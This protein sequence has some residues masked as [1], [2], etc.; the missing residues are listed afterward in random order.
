MTHTEPIDDDE[1]NLWLVAEFLMSHAK[2]LLLGGITGAIIGFGGW[3][4]FAP[5]KGELVVNVERL[6]NASP[7]IDYMTWRNHQQSLP[8][9][10][11]QM[12][13]SGKIKDET[14]LGDYK[15]FSNQQWWRKNVVPT[16]ALTKADTKSLF[17]ISKELQDTEANTIL[18]F[19]ISDRQESGEG[20]LRRLNLSADF[21][22]QGAAFLAI[23]SLVNRYESEAA[24]IASIQQ[25]ITQNEIELRFL[26]GRAKKLELLR[27]KFPHSKGVSSQQVLEISESNA[28]F[29]PVES[30]LIAVYTDIDRIEEQITRLY[31]ALDQLELKSQ[32][33]K[34]GV[35][36]LHEGANG[37]ELTE[38]LV[39]IA[40]DL[41]GKLKEGDQ[42]SLLT[43]GGIHADLVAVRTRFGKGLTK[44][45][46]TKPVKSGPLIP[47][48][49]GFMGAGFV[50]LMWLMLR[51]GWRRHYAES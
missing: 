48:V 24:D 12:V 40:L 21:I 7:S 20:V 35:P 28:K 1:I 33:V 37:L 13:E 29:M 15:T 31:L 22:Q 46:A 23:R 2:L 4:A 18:N 32:F 36:L 10:A 41:R 50:M 27:V 42:D 43:L 14:L 3:S 5:Y 49:G 51:Q 45:P 47:V 30:Q 9:L 39:G 19:V 8:L 38:R 34:L 25:E 6:G 17:A 11:L 44:N 26:Q 16:F